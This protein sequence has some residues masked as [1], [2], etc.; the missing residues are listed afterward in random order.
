MSLDFVGFQSDGTFPLIQQTSQSN[1]LRTLRSRLVCLHIKPKLRKKIK[2]NLKEDLKLNEPLT[3]RLLLLKRTKRKQQTTP[4]TITNNNSNDNEYNNMSRKLENVESYKKE[5][6]QEQE[7]KQKQKEKQKE[8]QKQ[9]EKEK[10]KEKEW[11]QI[12]M[13]LKKKSF[14]L[15][16]QKDKT[17][18]ISG[19]YHEGQRV[20]INLHDDTLFILRFDQSNEYILKAL[21]PKARDRICNLFLTLHLRFLTGNEIDSK[22]KQMMNKKE[23]KKEEKKEK[24]HNFKNFPLT[25]PSRL[26][27]LRIDKIANLPKPS[28]YNSISTK[29]KNLS[30]KHPRLNKDE[31]NLL[32]KIE[33]QSPS[34]QW[35]TSLYLGL[36]QPLKHNAY[37]LNGILEREKE[38]SIELNFN[39]FQIDYPFLGTN[40]IYPIQRVYNVNSNCFLVDETQEKS[41]IQFIIDEHSFFYL[42]FLTKTKMLSFVQ[43][44]E[45]KKKIHSQSYL[46]SNNSNKYNN[47]N[48]FYKNNNSQNK[49]KNININS[50]K[51][52]IKMY[53]C[54]IIID[55]KY[56]YPH[57]KR[58][59]KKSKIIFN[60]DHFLIITKKYNPLKIQ[61]Q[62]T[63]Y[64]SNLKKINQNNFSIKIWLNQS[65]TQY[66][67]LFFKKL[68]FIIL[69]ISTFEKFTKSFLKSNIDYLINNYESDNN[70]NNNNNNNMKIFNQN[71]K[72]HLNINPKL[73]SNLKHSLISYFNLNPYNLITKRQLKTRLQI[74][75]YIFLAHLKWDVSI[76]IIIKINL[77]N[78]KIY[79]N[80]KS[81]NFYEQD[82]ELKNLI[83]IEKGENSSNYNHKY[84][85]NEEE[86]DNNFICS[87]EF[88]NS[89]PVLLQFQ[90]LGERD[91]FYS[92]IYTRV[93]YLYYHIYLYSDE[94]KY[95]YSSYL[96]IRN[97]NELI[98]ELPNE[99]PIRIKKKQLELNLHPKFSHLITMKILKYQ[100]SFNIRFESDQKLLKFFERFQKTNFLN[101]EFLIQKKITL[102]VLKSKLSLNGYLLNDDNNKFEI[103]KKIK[104][105]ID[106]NGIII[107]FDKQSKRILFWIKDL[108][109]HINKMCTNVIKIHSKNFNQNI[110]LHSF[111]DLNNFVSILYFYALKIGQLK[112][113]HLK[114][115]GLETNL[116]TDD[117]QQNEGDVV[118]TGVLFGQENIEG[119]DSK[120]NKTDDVPI[121]HF[122]CQIIDDSL[123][124]LPKN[125]LINFIIFKKKNDQKYVLSLNW[126]NENFYEI[127]LNAKSSRLFI[128]PVNGNYIKLIL[129]LS[130]QIVFNVFTISNRNR[131]IS[132]FSFLKIPPWENKN[133]Q[134]TKMKNII[135]KFQTFKSMK[136]SKSKNK[137]NSHKNSKSN[138]DC[139]TNSNSCSHF[140]VDYNLE[141]GSGDEYNVESGSSSDS[142][143]YLISTNNL[144]VSSSPN[145]TSNS[146][147]SYDSSSDFEN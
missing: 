87:M 17:V 67:F 77:Q 146:S 98:L 40:A 75:E 39:Y 147:S 126:N 31:N 68:K 89:N 53:N 59:K 119:G 27:N 47:N 122:Y 123:N 132:C 101:K 34:E 3:F 72:N 41:I 60:K 11:I 15:N 90:T 51:R 113:M 70:N 56:N 125:Q 137:I 145:I 46:N 91:A 93:D 33:S 24:K 94:G 140:D 130:R 5:Q 55:R 142:S 49:N 7:Q 18:I 1:F 58:K 78:L 30:Q 71:C 129:P 65:K 116:I 100:F 6:E 92:L 28:K 136:L 62:K 23:E 107:K 73:N 13:T 25:L 99:L 115:M 14:V 2:T 111:N 32:K 86:I 54:E 63:I 43:D 117:F 134:I 83:Y 143:L 135:I 16:S 36:P 57:F 66:I 64:L 109:I 131:L 29:K 20:M 42:E 139:D 52:N 35:V 45:I 69:F 82:Y 106:T 124:H 22:Q 61:Y 74:R 120:A 8:K 38:I 133:Y 37:L 96:W 4:N 104:I 76:P 114:I 21:N 88:T 80:P 9:K 50:N 138:S 48:N 144:N 97:N 121:L 85:Q 26:C 10:E 79:F 12:A 128:S 112:N 108:A 118:G 103:E 95:I 81:H 44:F 105:K 84:N 102:N 127:I 19:S 110:L 141:S